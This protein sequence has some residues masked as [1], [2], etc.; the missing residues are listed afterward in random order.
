MPDTKMAPRPAMTKERREEIDGLA[1][2]ATLRGVDWP[3]RGTNPHYVKIGDALRDCLREIDRRGELVGR[4]A[5]CVRLREGHDY[6]Y[7]QGRSSM[8]CPICDLRRE[9]DEMTWLSS[10][11]VC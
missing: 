11:W 7:H 8:G 3:K 6:T 10:F 4:L 5:E 9:A 1:N 2:S